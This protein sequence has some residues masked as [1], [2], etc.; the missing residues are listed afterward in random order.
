MLRGED[1]QLDQQKLRKEG[2]KAVQVFIELGPA[3]V[4]LGQL[5]SAR[6]DILPQA[7][8]EEF[9]K[10]QDEVPPAPFSAVRQLI[11]ADLGPLEQ[12]FERFDEEALSGASLGQ[13]YRARV[14][15][16]EVV[17]K[18][19][20][21]HIHDLVARDIAVVRRAIPLL[22]RF[23]DPAIVFSI[24]SALEQFADT[25]HEEMDYRVEAQNLERIRR[26][27]RG[28]RNLQIPRVYPA[29][30]TQRVLTLEYLPGVKIT[31][32]A[33]IEQLGLDRR[34]VA[35]RVDR[36]FLRMLL[37]HDLFH[38]DPHPGNI[39]LRPDGTLILYDFGMTGALDQETRLRLI[40]LY[41]ALAD[42]NASQIVSLLLELGA[43]QPDVNRAVIQRGID[44]ALQTWQGKKVDELEVKALM[45]VANRTIYQFPFKL[46]KHLVLYMRMSGI[47]EGICLTLDP[48]FHFIRV[49][50]SL[51]EEE[52]LMGEAY[53][54]ELRDA[55]RKLGKAL[56]ATIEVAPMLHTF[57]E[58][59]GASGLPML[60]RQR[61]DRMLVT[62]MLTAALVV[63][64]AIIYTTN[65][66]L[67]QVGFV[68]AAIV[69]VGGWLASRRR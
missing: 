33:S 50:R 7:Y 31:D 30:S 67:G 63:A 44:L 23:L 34:R 11:E 45:Q 37:K 21:P 39:A 41:I 18:V 43:L 8:I 59:M 60:Q 69:F 55:V 17:V 1:R 5:L 61:S 64:S 47:L 16:E 38:A 48:K 66:F 25:V 57:L 3:F 22:V 58:S 14:R 65:T 13:V 19:N 53:R 20:R 12:V 26:N 9:A 42:L 51:L 32:T 29:L 62:G 28:E 24:E 2:R 52:G 40:R 4:K 46:P 10:L 15:G 49:L 36:L 35:I 54:E 68:G 56:E 6:P 27:L